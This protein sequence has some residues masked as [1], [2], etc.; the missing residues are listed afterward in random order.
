MDLLQLQEAVG[1]QVR[2]VRKRKKC[3]QKRLADVLGCDI[4]YLSDIENG[5][6]PLT[7][8]V[9]HKIEAYI[10]PI[11]VSEIFDAEKKKNMGCFL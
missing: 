8:W 9:L 3:T 2:L 7:T 4:H 1:N 10:G 11:W 6:T 5:L